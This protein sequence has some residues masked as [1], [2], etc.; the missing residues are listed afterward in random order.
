M[1]TDA[2]HVKEQSSEVKE[3]M[4]SLVEPHTDE[5]KLSM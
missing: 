4:L 2:Q 3:S 1:Y 5:V